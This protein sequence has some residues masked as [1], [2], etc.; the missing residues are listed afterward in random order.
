M[1]GADATPRLLPEVTKAY[2]SLRQ[3]FPRM[4]PAMA[5]RV[6]M[7]GLGVIGASATFAKVKEP[8]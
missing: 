4:R 1:M 2:H 7:K 5:W 6:A 3:R 8:K